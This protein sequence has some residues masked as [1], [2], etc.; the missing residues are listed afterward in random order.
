MFRSAVTYVAV[1]TLA[2][3]LT[4][5]AAAGTP[6]PPAPESSTSAPNVAVRSPASA[7]LAVGAESDASFASLITGVASAAISA[8][9]LLLSVLAF[10][11]S[12]AAEARV[13]RPI[14]VFEYEAK[15]G[16]RVVNAGAGLAVNV[17]VCFRGR[18]SPWTRLIALPALP[19]GAAFDL[20]FL[21]SLSVWMLSAAYDDVGGCRRS[22]LSQHDQNWFV[23]GDDLRKFEEPNRDYVTGADAV[24][25]WNAPDLSN[26]AALS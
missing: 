19:S 2:M 14:L 15:K 26:E 23:D 25:Y 5:G 3:A 9:S 13:R 12:R 24:R 16:W 6:A 1:A 20:T 21:G 7:A 22:T 4:L 17:G 18:E 10:N 11:L 8:L